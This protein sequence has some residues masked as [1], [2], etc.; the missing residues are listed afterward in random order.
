VLARAPTQ[1]RRDGGYGPN[2][3]HIGRT[4]H[5][6]VGP[7]AGSYPGVTSYWTTALSPSAAYMTLMFAA[8]GQVQTSVLQF[9]T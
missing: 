5:H 9:P 2:V 4:P 6:C 7:L 8:G 1:V 3:I